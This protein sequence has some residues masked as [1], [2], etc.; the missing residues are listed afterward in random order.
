MK[1]KWKQQLLRL[2]GGFVGQIPPIGGL[3]FKKNPTGGTHTSLDTRVCAAHLLLLYTTKRHLAR[4]F[5]QKTQFCAES[6]RLTTIFAHF[7]IKTCQNG[8]TTPAATERTILARIW[9]N[10]RTGGTQMPSRMYKNKVGV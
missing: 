3:F 4:K 10:T 6:K 2:A 1:L 8:R 9:E 7:N 5:R